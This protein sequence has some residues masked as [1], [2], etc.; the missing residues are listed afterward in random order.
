MKIDARWIVAAVLIFFAWKG[1]DLSMPWPPAPHENIT[2][3]Q[4]DAELLK[5]AEPLR[6][7]L[8]KMLPKD[9]QYLAAFYDAMAFVLIRDRQRELPI[10]GSTEQFAN[11]H[12]GSLRLAIDK[13]NVG[14]YP[15]LAEAIDETF[16]NACGAE[17]QKIDEKV[18][19]RLVAA[20]GV[21]SWS[22]GI[23]HE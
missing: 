20:C 2:T 17:V 16:I 13:A 22:L 15:G 12:G 3:P 10:I 4:P 14:K 8:P 18:G 6:P 19:S 5:W 11:F 7:I 9:R 1:S 21:L 23:G